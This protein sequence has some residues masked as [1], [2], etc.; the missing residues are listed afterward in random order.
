MEEF[1]YFWGSQR[2][3]KGIVLFGSRLFFKRQRFLCHLEYLPAFIG[4]DYR[5]FAIQELDHCIVKVFNN[6]RVVSV[7]HCDAEGLFQGFDLF[8]G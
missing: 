1:V 7:V 3:S 8:G 6:V 5:A 2:E 4:S